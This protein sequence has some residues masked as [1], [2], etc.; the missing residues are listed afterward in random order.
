MSK[1]IDGFLIPVPKD[2][3]SKYQE[4]ALLASKVW[5][6]YGALDY[7]EAVGDDFPVCGEGAKPGPELVGASADETL[8][9]AYIVYESREH[10]DAVNAKVMEDPRMQEICPSINGIFDTKR[11]IFGGFRAIVEA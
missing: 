10:R 6:E 3:M 11:M 8:V 2:N 1:Y 9:F 5:K 7:V 4:A